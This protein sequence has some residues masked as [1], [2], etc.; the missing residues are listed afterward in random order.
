MCCA[1]QRR[2]LNEDFVERKSDGA[3]FCIPHTLIPQFVC[4]D[5][6]VW[7]RAWA[8]ITTSQLVN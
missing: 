6:L 8:E 1:V 5:V 7:L 3:S 2:A 4:V